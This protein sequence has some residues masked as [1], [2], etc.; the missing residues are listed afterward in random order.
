MIIY[1]IT[2]LINHKVYI[3]QTTRP[4]EERMYEYAAQSRKIRGNSAIHR[5]INRYKW[6]NFTYE[7][8]DIAETIDELNEKEKYYIK[9]FESYNRKYGYNILEGGRNS[10]PGPETRKKMSEAHKGIKQSPE[11]IENRI[12]KAGSMEAQN[13]G[14]NKT[15]EEKQYLSE[16]SPKFWQGK[17][18]SEETKEKISKTKLEKNITNKP[19]QLYKSVYKKD[20]STNEIIQTYDSTQI[21]SEFENVDQS[22]ISRWCSNNKIVRGFLWTYIK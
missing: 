7:I 5:S 4:I 3:G 8:L 18:R 15:L 12:H 10:K 11:W 20:F 16:N 14:R 6:K 17:N 13:Y 21:A 9:N 19:T 2:N 1:K 22:T